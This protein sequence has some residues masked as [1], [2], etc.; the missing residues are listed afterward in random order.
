MLGLH[1][2]NKDLPT[3]IESVTKMTVLLQVL[4]HEPTKDSVG[5]SIMQIDTAKA[6]QIIETIVVHLALLIENEGNKSWLD[7][8]SLL[9]INNVF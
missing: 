9:T 5:D 8:Q 1:R 6:T 2:M 7:N 4:S 3:F